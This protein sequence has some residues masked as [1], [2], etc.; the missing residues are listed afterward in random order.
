VVLLVGVC[1]VHF[2]EVR[3]LAVWDPQ[4]EEGL[5]NAETNFSATIIFGGRGLAYCIL[6]HCH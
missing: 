2:D 4:P 3:P 1:I 6:H 5:D